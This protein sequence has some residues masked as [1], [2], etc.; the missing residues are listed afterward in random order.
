LEGRIQVVGG[1]DLVL[2][3]PDLGVTQAG[4]MNDFV[5]G[6]IFPD[7]E[8]QHGI[9]KYFG[10]GDV[11]QFVKQRSQAPLEAQ[12]PQCVLHRVLRPGEAAGFVV[13]RSGTIDLEIDLPGVGRVGRLVDD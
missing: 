1:F 3:P 8:H 7:G 2:Q 11:R 12:V 13:A 9:V 5:V 4:Q 6:G 10:D